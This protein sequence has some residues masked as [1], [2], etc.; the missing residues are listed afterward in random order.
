MKSFIYKGILLVCCISS[1]SA[2]VT[3]QSRE[4]TAQ[5][6]A[7]RQQMMQMFMSR[8][9]AKQIQSQHTAA[10]PAAASATQLAGPSLTETEL[11]QQIEQL[12]TLESGVKFTDKK[13][14]FDVDGNRYLDPEG[15]ILTYGYDYATGDVTYL[16]A[17]ND[18]DYVIKFTRVLT[19]AEPLT[20][21]TAHREGGQWQVR[22]ASGRNLTGN[23]L[24]PTSRGFIVGRDTV[25][26]RYTPGEG[27]GNF[28]ALE[29][30][31][32]A[33]FQNGDV[34][35]TGYVLLEKEAT[36]QSKQ[37]LFASFKSIGNTLG[38][39][40][41]EDYMLVNVDTG[42]AYPINI[43][44]DDKQAAYYSRCRKKN[45]MVNICDEV[46]FRES[47]YKPDGFKNHGH[48]Y[49]RITWLNTR[50]GPILVAQE[51]G[52][53]DLTL[54][55]LNTGRKLTL[56]HRAMGLNGFDVEQDADG[57]VNLTLQAGFEK[58]Y[59]DDLEQ[60]I[61]SSIAEA[62]STSR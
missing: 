26:F 6:M 46:N 61:A 3:N 31:H 25:A 32:L 38:L 43:P 24:I 58:K 40:K 44:L 19:R 5:E 34:A 36:S 33:S 14:G 52:L 20:I 57:K 53:M 27:I 30:F 4:L 35:T 17:L 47:L 50:S 59:F 51:N 28:S 21:A 13:D 29:G 12:P 39:N 49:W 60:L 45:W 16:A 11:K 15:K 48:Y 42:R 9:N 18:K 22:T 10:N 54:T 7:E 41:Q 62:E 55:D 23:S 37:D 1:L 2:C 56:Y 8:M